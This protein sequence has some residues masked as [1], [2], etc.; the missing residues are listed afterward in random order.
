MGND[1]WGQQDP[2]RPSG[3]LSKSGHSLDNTRSKPMI[4]AVK[5]P[6]KFDENGMYVPHSARQKKGI[7]HTITMS[8]PRRKRFGRR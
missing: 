2:L 6:L 5:E 3:K 1:R 7:T 8:L 4:K